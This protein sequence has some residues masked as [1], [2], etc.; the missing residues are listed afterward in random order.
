MN[1]R[2]REGYHWGAIRTLMSTGADLVIMQMQDIL[3]LDNS[4][5]MNTPSTL[6]GNWQWRLKPD[7][8]TAS[9]LSRLRLM[10]KTY[11]RQKKPKRKT[12]R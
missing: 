2:L 5:R 4:A 11:A 12:D 3:G 6:G 10:T 1:L 8:L 7:W 9:V